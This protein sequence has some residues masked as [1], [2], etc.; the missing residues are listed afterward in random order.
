VLTERLEGSMKKMAGARGITVAEIQKE[1]EAESP[2]GRFASMAECAQTALFL[3]SEDSS[4]MTG[5]ALNVTAGV[6][7]S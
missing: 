6:L 2:M 5:Q 4:G 7:M 3:A 1:W